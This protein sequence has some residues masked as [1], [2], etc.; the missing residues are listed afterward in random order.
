[1][2]TRTTMHPLKIL[3]AAGAAFLVWGLLL[4]YASS[5][6]YADTT[7]TVNSTGDQN[8]IDLPGGAFDG[9]S[10][11]KC[12]VDSTLEGD[13]CTLRAAIQEANVTAGDDTIDIG[14]TGTVN[15]TE[16]LPDLSSNI[17]IV[18]PGADQFTVRRAD[19]A[20]DFRIFHVTGDTTV[21]TIS[22]ITISNGNVPS[23]SGGGILNA[24]AGTV[25]VTDSTISGNTADN[26]GGIANDGDGSLTVG[27]STISDNTAFDEGGGIY[28]LTEFPDDD[29]D[30]DPDTSTTITNSTISGNSAESEGVVG[31]AGGGVL[32][33]SGLTVIEFSTIT[34][35][36]AP[37]GQGSGVASVE[38]NFTPTE[39]LSSIISANKGTDV[40]FVLG[41]DNNSFVSNGYNLIG[42]DG[43]ATGAFN[44]TGDQVA[45]V[46][47]IN[48]ML[49]PLA[50][51]GGPTQT[52]ALLTGSPAID[53]GPPTDGVPIAC[54][55][56]AIDQRGVTRPWDGNADS[57]PRCDIGSFELT[58]TNNVPQAQDD[59][60]ST[61]EDTTLTVAASAGVL[62]NDEDVDNAKAD[63]KAVLVSGPSHGQLTLK[64]DGSFTYTPTHRLPTTTALTPSRTR[65]TKAPPTVTWLR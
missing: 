3:A 64:N 51:N 14:V 7:F 12:D 62:D 30:N 33:V 18:G 56:P 47:N 25:T 38:G 20:E 28:S 37:N 48:A 55:P 31:A 36:T 49:G 27:G 61:D 11:A 17:E 13:Q 4:A 9:S 63:L 19:T 45:T 40:D 57:T 32:N 46:N 44:N 35:N 59:A 29:P 50:D 43:N 2:M 52:H 16:V 21:V 53:A 60:Y 22:G 58:D 41:D 42:D 1:M 24:D 26:G 65:P 8:D 5:L 39:V 10:D 15:L 54:P 23:D 6:A 34:N